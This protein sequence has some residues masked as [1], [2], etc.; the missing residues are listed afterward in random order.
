ML[1]S[2]EMGKQVGGKQVSRRKIRVSFC[3][4]GFEMPVRPRREGGPVGIVSVML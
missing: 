2:V 1:C 4:V 3:A